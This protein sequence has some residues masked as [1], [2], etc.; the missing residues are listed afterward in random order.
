MPDTHALFEELVRDKPALRLDV[1]AIERRGE[2]AIRRRRVLGGVIIFVAAGSVAIG[3]SAK[4]PSRPAPAGPSAPTGLAFTSAEQITSADARVVAAML[5]TAGTGA[6][7]TQSTPSFITATTRR[8][9]H[10]ISYQ[11]DGAKV[12]LLENVSAPGGASELAN[13]GITGKDQ[14]SPC[15]TPHHPPAT[16]PDGSIVTY[17]TS[18]LC[19]GQPLPDGATLWTFVTHWGNNSPDS[20]PS[21]VIEEPDGSTVF[22]QTGATKAGH[23]APEAMTR[24]QVGALAIALEKAWQG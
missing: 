9:I 19:V 20:P 1:E 21:A 23:D 14:N 15:A 10:E 4:D 16:Q 22:V 12:S 5:T 8:T 2:R 6:K 18:I 13:L 7:V 24:D 17:A 3:V 11:K